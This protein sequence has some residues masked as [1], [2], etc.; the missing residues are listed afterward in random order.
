MARARYQNRKWNPKTGTWDSEVE[1]I[2]DPSETMPF[3]RPSVPIPRPA[4]VEPTEDEEPPAR[5]VGLVIVL[6]GMGLGLVL[7]TVLIGLVALALVYL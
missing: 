7:M 5:S 6:V 1:H 2:P 4:G 3:V